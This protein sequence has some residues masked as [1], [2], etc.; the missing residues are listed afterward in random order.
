ML[1][2]AALRALARHRPG[3]LRLATSAL[4]SLPDFLI[5]GAQKG[6]TTSIYRYL[7]MHPQVRFG[8]VKEADYFSNYSFGGER[9]Y[10]AQFPV[11]APWRHWMIGDASP[12]YLFHPHAADRAAE[13]LPGAKL[14]AV[15]RNPVD[16]AYSHYQH[17]VSRGHEALDFEAA[18]ER[19]ALAVPVESQRML[20]DPAYRSLTHERHSYVS[21][22]EY[23]RQLERWL[24]RF[25]RENLFVLQSEQMFEAPNAVMAR[26]Y[27][28]LG[29][30]AIRIDDP[31]QFKRGDYDTGMPASTRARLAAH[32]RPHNQRLESLLSMRFFWDG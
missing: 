6:G 24:R 1:D 18:L 23:A 3:R 25:P 29:L 8:R 30:D 22:G 2:D 5:I 31:G 11:R 21:R 26:V 13:L 16:R 4:R 32:F 14:V 9:W 12:Y 17:V 27:E 10:R 28:F 19:E 20:D 7:S 15:L